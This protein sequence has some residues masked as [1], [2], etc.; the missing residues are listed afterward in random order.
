MVVIGA[1]ELVLDDDVEGL[2]GVRTCCLTDNVDREVA[3]RLLTLQRV[4]IDV[5]RQ[6]FIEEVDVLDKP[7]REILL[8]VRPCVTERHLLNSVG[9]SGGHPKPQ[10]SGDTIVVLVSSRSHRTT[11]H[12]S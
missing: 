8:L 10:G 1:F 4:R 7:S 9:G 5:E 6:V 3:G 11:G 12:E 2:R